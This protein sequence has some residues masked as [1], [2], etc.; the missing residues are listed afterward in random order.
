MQSVKRFAIACM[1]VSACSSFE[2][3]TDEAPV[4]DAGTEA[5]VTP[6]PPPPPTAVPP[7]VDAGPPNLLP[8]G[9]FETGCGNWLPNN[10]KLT[11]DT[12]A[13]RGAQ[14][15]RVCI[16]EIDAGAFS[17]SSSKPIAR[18]SGE[19][20]GEIWVRAAPG[21]PAPDLTFTLSIHGDQPGPVAS[22][23]GPSGTLTD[24]W[25]RIVATA[26][27]GAK[28]GTLVNVDLGAPVVPSGACFLVDDALVYQDK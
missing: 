12:T 14:S 18:T 13:H 19:F 28:E 9:D 15:C 25:T 10:A 1:I 6:P 24:S 8:N 3:S 23:Y 2:S 17:I 27:T 16:V 21:V 5:A 4:V 11:P 20:Q 26:D 22:A 7:A